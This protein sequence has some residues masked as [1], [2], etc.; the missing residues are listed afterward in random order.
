M[1][2]EVQHSTAVPQPACQGPMRLAGRAAFLARLGQ[3]ITGRRHAGGDAQRRALRK[4]AQ[5][6]QGK[7]LRLPN[8]HATTARL[9]A[10]EPDRDRWQRQ[11]CC[12][13]TATTALHFALQEMIVTWSKCSAR[14]GRSVRCSVDRYGFG[15]RASLWHVQSR[16][17]HSALASLP[18]SWLCASHMSAATA[19]AIGRSSPPPAGAL[20]APARRP[21]RAH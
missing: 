1:S 18:K 2:P 21:V 17:S 7:A 3:R 6:L 16:M 14:D 5:R 20:Q 19:R 10:A 12:T 11:G 8:L 9:P 15:C 13:C 4:H